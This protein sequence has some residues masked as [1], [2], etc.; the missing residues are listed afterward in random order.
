MNQRSLP[1]VSYNSNGTHVI[2]HIA[3]RRHAFE[4]LRDGTE[5]APA[6]MEAEMSQPSQLDRT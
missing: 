3:T 4:T 2:D 5:S 6:R 1:P